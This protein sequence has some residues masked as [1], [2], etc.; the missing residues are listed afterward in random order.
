MIRGI[1]TDIDGVMIGDKIGYNTPNPH[2]DVVKRITYIH[3]RGIPIILA[4]GKPHYAIGKIIED[5]ALD[6]PHV[7]DGGAI[8]FDKIVIKKHVIDPAV[9]SA[10]VETFITNN[11]YVEFYTE[12][13]YFIQRSQIRDNLTP[14]H[15]HI[16]QTPPI[17]VENLTIESTKHD[18]IKIVPIATDPTDEQ[19]IHSLSAPYLSRIMLAITVHPIAN[20]HRFGI[21]TAPDV[22]KKQS[23][24][25]AAEPLGIPLSDYLGIGDSTSDWSFMQL[26]GATAT[27]S[28]GSQE[29][30]KLVTYISPKSVDENGILDILNHF[31]L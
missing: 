15:T 7:T 5:C 16:L 31:K 12:K 3:K 17:I 26:C 11:M 4:T 9:I 22:S 30:K 25:D 20:P 24:I 13:G 14:V 6:N 1:I 10:L 23:A 18:V 19:R 21:I 8:L 2:S 27:V 29:L 28:N